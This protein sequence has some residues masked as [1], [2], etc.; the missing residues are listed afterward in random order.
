MAK[1]L[2]R[3]QESG[4]YYEI[5]FEYSPKQLPNW[6][7]IKF[8]EVEVG[9]YISEANLPALIPLLATVDSPLKIFDVGQQG[10]A[11][12]TYDKKEGRLNIEGEKKK[13]SKKSNIPSGGI[14]IR[15]W[16]Y[17]PK[18]GFYP[19]E[20]HVLLRSPHLEGIAI[21]QAL[22]EHGT[23]IS[24]FLQGSKIYKDRVNVSYQLS[25][26][27]G[28]NLHIISYLFEPDD[29]TKGYSRLI[30]DWAYIDDDGFYPIEGKRMDKVETVI[31]LFKVAEFV[32]QNRAWL[33]TID[34]FHTHIRSLEYQ[35]GYEVDSDRRLSFTRTI[36]QTQG[37]ARMQD[38]GSWVYQEGEGFYSK[39]ASPLGFLLKPGVSMGPEQVPLFIKINREEL[40]LVT[41]FFASAC[42][43][44]NASLKVELTPNQ[45]VKVIPEY[46]LVTKYENQ[47]LIFFDDFVYVPG[48]G[49]H[50]LPPRLRLPEKY[51]QAVELQGEERDFFLT[52]ELEQL[53][54]VVKALDTRLLKPDWC[55]LV[56]QSLSQAEEKGRGWV[57]FDLSYKTD[58]G[59]IPIGEIHERMKK[60]ERFAFFEAG[61]L[62][63]DDERYE[64]IR[65]LNKDR[66]DKKGKKVLLTTLEF[67]RLKAFDPISL[68][69]SATEGRDLWDQLQNLHTPDDPDLEGLNSHLRP[70]QDLGVKWL[71]FLYQQRLS[72]L[73]CDDMGLGKTHQT[74]GL[75]AGIANLFHTLA[76]G[77]QRHFLIVCP[78]SV[79]YH[80]MDKLHEFLPNL[81]VYP[82]YGTKRNLEQFPENYDI[83]LTSY[84]ILRNEIKLLSKI[85]FELAVFDEIQIAK[86]HSSR[87]YNALT[88]VDAQ[89]RVGL[90]GTPI[91]NYL[92]ELKS[93]FDIV[94][95]GYMPGD[96]DYRS[97]FIRPI[98][99]EGNRARQ[100][101]LNRL[102]Q[103]FLLRRRKQDVLT[104]LPEKTEE[105]SY[106]DLLSHQHQ[107]YL[108][109]LEQRRKPILEELQND[110]LQIPYMHIFALLSSLKQ[111]CDHPAVYYKKPEDYTQ[112]V[113]GKWELFIELLQEAR[114]SRQ[115]VVVFSQYLHMLDIIEA[116]LT[117]QRI[118]FSSLR[119]STTDRK[120]QIDQ[121]NQDPACEVFVA[122]LQA[123]GL[124]IDLTAGSVVIHYDR[125]WNAARENQATDRVHR[126]GQTRGV[127]V[128]K[129]VTKETFEEKIDAMILRKGKLMEE[130]IGADDH[131]T[132]KTFTREELID[133]IS[134]IEKGEEHPD[135][136][137]QE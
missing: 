32:S 131:A 113:S 104:D 40:N 36:S 76:Q 61:L 20:S 54:S 84:G 47:P 73:L 7:E 102:I 33:N 48:H 97:L 70:Y 53:K 50:E 25:F 95:P 85:P 110:K 112:H 89:M 126:I 11:S 108:E 64:W 117:E 135:I 37:K 46:E 107:L 66:I 69:E 24:N 99:K 94:L 9:F 14:E 4:Q 18:K 130:V 80:W 62:D 44:L 42:P 74:M 8:E 34:G 81:R 38:F 134:Y 60:K 114:E 56:A 137:D 19:E 12:I 77:V 22:T 101:L 59:L 125:W 105:V 79:I 27:S 82:F 29:L 26:D 116:Y 63:L 121:F 78:T 17:I 88:M 6:I 133:L 52:Y 10:I 3:F 58:R 45:N 39:T 65:Q 136:R 43:V 51:R 23:Y 100:K 111:I 92:R 31:P 128:F 1:W 119:G 83:L 120:E 90:T 93:L 71:W 30:G 87:V 122:S 49:F 106:C 21:S 5:A 98:E 2:L 13:G 129:L 75:V 15:G 124:G 55:T 86:N 16:T 96:T 72:G 91:E 109:V 115:K 28:W 123:A 35:L 67:M 118:G 103:P 68:S 41:G 132:L 127:Q 57:H